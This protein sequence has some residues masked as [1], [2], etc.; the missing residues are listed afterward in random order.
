MT[1]RIEVGGER[2]YQVLVGRD[3]LGDQRHFFRARLLAQNIGA[4]AGQGAPVDRAAALQVPLARVPGSL[5]H[6]KERFTRGNNG[7]DP[8]HGR[9]VSLSA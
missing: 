7:L 2:P 6:E 5:V 1:T 3:L 8:L 9:C 4:A